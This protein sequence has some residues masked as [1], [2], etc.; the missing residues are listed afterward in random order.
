MASR[1]VFSIIGMLIDER[2]CLISVA[3]TAGLSLGH[4]SQL[5]FILGTM[6]VVAIGTVDLAFFYSMAARQGELGC[7]IEMASQ[8]LVGDRARFKDQ[9]G[10]GMDRM[11]GRAGYFVGGMDPGVPVMDIEGRVGGMTLQADQGHSP[12]R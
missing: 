1:T 10:T 2:A 8:T 11:A 5:E 12:G 9:I 7:D 4:G 6:R 3:A